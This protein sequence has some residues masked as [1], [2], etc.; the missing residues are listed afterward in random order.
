MTEPK[1]FSLLEMAIVL[2]VIGLLTGGLLLPLSAQ[3]D[4]QKIKLTVQRLEEIKEALLGYAVIYQRL[5][6]PAV[7]VNGF[8][9]TSN[10]TK[11][12][13]IPWAEL[14]IGRYDGWGNPFHYRLEDEY[15]QPLINLT[16]NNNLDV[17]SE[18]RVSA[19]KSAT[20]NWLTNKTIDSRVVAI[21]FSCG[22]NGRSDPT[23]PPSGEP[24]PPVNID[25][26]FTNDADGIRNTNIQCRIVGTPKSTK[27]YVSDLPIK[28]GF[29]DQLTWLSKYTLITRLTMAEQWPPLPPQP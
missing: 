24:L 10:C 6:C 29:D 25:Y 28:D 7:D 2:I 27:N 17:S 23:P 4:Q 26:S 8:Q 21:I 3:V 14:G 13:Y 1:G 18:L 9:N 11:E 19:V 5:P 16:N 15:A 22:K 12:G 20:Q